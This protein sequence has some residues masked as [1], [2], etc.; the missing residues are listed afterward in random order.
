VSSKNRRVLVV[1]D[2]PAIHEDFK[3]TL[4]VGGADHSELRR[5]EETLF[6][7]APAPDSD[8]FEVTLASQGEEALQAVIEARLA[9]RPFAMAFVDMRMPPGWDGT[10]TIREIWAVDPDVQIVVC[11]AYA[12]GDWDDVV[13]ELGGSDRL[14]LLKKPFD[15]AEAFQLASALT[16]KWELARQAHLKLDEL[17]ALVDDQTRKLRHAALHDTLTG[18]TNR[19]HLMERLG[20]CFERVKAN[21][22][23]GF[24]VMFVDLDRFKMV[25]DSLGHLVGDA[26]L[27][28]MASRLA[29]CVRAT[30]TLALSERSDLHRIGGDEFVV[31]L[32]GMADAAHAVAVAERLLAAVVTPFRV[33]QHDIH[34]S[35]SIGIAIGHQDYDR[36]E[37]VLRDADTALYKAKADGRGRYRVFHED[38]HASAMTRWQLENELRTAIERGELFLQY[39]PVVATD[40][41]ETIH[42]EALVRWRHPTRG[43][44]PPSQF[45]PLAEETGLIVSLGRWVIGEACRQLDEWRQHLGTHSGLAVAVNVASRQFLDPSFVDDVVQQLEAAHLPPSVLKLEITE[46]A[47]MSPRAIETCA[48]LEELGLRMYLDDF[49]TGYSSLSH[50][51]RISI[52][53]LKIDRSFIATACESAR[54]ASIVRAILALADALGLTTVA[55]GVETQEQLELLRR[56][57]CPEGQ[58]WLWAAALDPDR[59]LR[60]LE[61]EHSATHFDVAC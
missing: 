23:P 31:L 5:I 3:K 50:L 56:L 59:A 55:E 44:V 8:P 24:A 17:H 33:D 58:G 20:E 52:H 13:A 37:D 10:R 16:E 25:N 34:T 22:S 45:I 38:L 19:A 60:R 15:A 47:M 9:Q 42:F 18:L 12:D 36:V 40:T 54:S 32:E 2:N 29:S 39:Q 4:R 1:D 49:G 14:L 57:G 21:R 30:D 53:G 46:S 28:A 11:T 41:G 43:L 61:A 35:I 6:G 7:T 51:H 26:L 48:R 27:V